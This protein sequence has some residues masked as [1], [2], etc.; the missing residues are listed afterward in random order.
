MTATALTSPARS[1]TPFLALRWAG[2][3]LSLGT[4]GVIAAFAFGEGTPKPSE[5]LL[6][7]FF[8]IGLLVGLV[9]AWWREIPGAVVALGSMAAFYAICFVARG[10][11][12]TGPWFAVLALPAVVFLIAGVLAR[13]M[14]NEGHAQGA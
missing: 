12:P 7:A 11:V 1:R 13:G 6:L 10:G 9:L 5:W 14:R 4:I 2:R 8:P 3:L